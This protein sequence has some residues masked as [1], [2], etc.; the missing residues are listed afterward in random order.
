MQIT[1]TPV[2]ETQLLN[3]VGLL[4]K[5]NRSFNLTAV[6]DP[7][8]MVTRHLL[9]SLSVF[10][11][12]CPLTQ[13][14]LDV[15]TGAGLP[16]IPLAISCTTKK[17]T[18]LDNNYKKQVFVG[19]AIQSLGLKNAQAVQ[20]NVKA[21]EPSQKFSTIITRAFADPAKMIALCGHLLRPQGRFLAMRGKV[22]EEPPAL[23]EGY[24]IEQIIILSVPGLNEQRHL[25]VIKREIEQEIEQEGKE[26]HGV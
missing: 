11:Y 23:P 17:I 9:D 7:A 8:Q 16:G 12:L 15:G 25:A 13:D 14:I 5:W 4:D 26:S 19:Q 20:C 3:Y 22:S 18:L 1:L 10:P 21:Y 2:Q 6:K 24:H